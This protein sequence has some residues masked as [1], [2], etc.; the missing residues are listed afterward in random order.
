MPVRPPYS[1]KTGYLKGVTSMREWG[2]SLKGGQTGYASSATKGAEAQLPGWQDWSA[3]FIVHNHLAIVV[4]GQVF[5]FGGSFNGAAGITGSVIIDELDM[6]WDIE[7]A[8]AIEQSIKAS[9]NGPYGIGACAVTETAV[10]NPL[11]SFGTYG[12]LLV[13]T[14]GGSLTRVPGIKSMS[15]KLSAKNAEYKD[16]DTDGWV[17]RLPG[18]LTGSVDFGV[19]VSDASLLPVPGTYATVQ[20]YVPGVNGAAPSEFWKIKYVQFGD[21][22]GIKVNRET[23]AVVG[24]TLNAKFSA[25]WNGNEGQIVGPSGVTLWP[26]A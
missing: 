16:S 26:P 8:K 18:V 25:Y 23:G 17:Y 22:S 21:I 3:D 1:G 12:S 9:G 19:N 10:Q 6:S 5:D 24:A 7:G 13:T 20:L 11:S 4:P 14:V 15:M 2:V